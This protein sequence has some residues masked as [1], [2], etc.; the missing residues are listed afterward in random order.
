MKF[1]VC[2]ASTIKIPRAFFPEREFF[3]QISISAR[4]NEPEPHSERVSATK[5]SSSVL[6]WCCLL[7]SSR[8]RTVGC[9]RPYLWIDYGPASA[10]G[11][12]LCCAALLSDPTGSSSSSRV[13][14]MISTYYTET[15][16]PARQQFK[17]DIVPLNPQ[18][19][20]QLRLSTH[21]R[22]ACRCRKTVV[23]VATIS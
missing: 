3:F 1:D 18:A 16:E 14:D 4:E 11:R 20:V 23:N 12:L 15:R 5:L 9:A 2:T 6:V 10:G 8:T 7:C 22:K 13:P 17:G 21:S 19:D